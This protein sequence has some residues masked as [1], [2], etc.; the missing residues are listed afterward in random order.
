MPVG[1]EGGGPLLK[2]RHVNGIT[3]LTYDLITS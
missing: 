1:G 2:Y 3:M